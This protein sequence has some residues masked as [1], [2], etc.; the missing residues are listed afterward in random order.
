MQTAE[1]RDPLLTDYARSL[2][3]F[4]A[5]QLARQCGFGP[6][7]RDDLEQ[8][9][10]LA[11]VSQA[12]RYDPERASLDTFIDRVVNTAAGMPAR[13]RSRLKRAPG[14]G[15]LSLETTKVP[16]RGQVQKPLA[17]FLCDADLTRRTGTVPTDEVALRENAEAIAHA[18]A[19]MPGP[20]RDVCRLVMRGSISSAARRLR[21]SRRRVR[22]LLRAARPYFEEA[23]LD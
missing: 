2:V 13:S 20:M 5:R 16:I 15:A 12:D 8:E 14:D 21:T 18:L 23:G 19:A 7:E 3:K 6:S 11:L 22:G 4:K 1:A 9:L 10:W 17:R